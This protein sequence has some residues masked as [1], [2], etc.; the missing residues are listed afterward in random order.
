VNQPAAALEAL[1][2]LDPDRGS[3]RGWAP[4]WFTMTHALHLLGRHAEELTA[5]RE[6][7]RRH[8]DSR[9][10]WV[11]EVRALAALG[12]APAVDSLLRAAAT[13]PPD[14]YWSLGAAMV[15]AGEELVAHGNPERAS[16]YFARAERW[17]A[18]QLARDPAHNAHRYW[19][20]SAHYD[21]GRFD[22][23]EPY[24]ASLVEDAPADIT[25]RGMYALVAAHGGD[26]ALARQR[27]GDPP[28]FDR[29]SHTAYRARVAAVAADR[30][31]AIALL[32]E[33]LSQGVGGLAWI[34]SSAQLDLASLAADERFARL[35]LL[36]ARGR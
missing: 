14:T 25:F 16:T 6:L 26:T 11:H 31:R 36:A 24:F 17:L 30:E 4:Y 19:L 2:K 8:P 35:G 28:R 12:Q 5:A 27:L 7:R 20:G 29:G 33:A 15:T 3:I 32:S 22:D 9:A 21:R 34:H 10:G 23:A 1:Q 13:L 18:N